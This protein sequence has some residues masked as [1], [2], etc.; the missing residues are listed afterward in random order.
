MIE[1]FTKVA[2]QLRKLNNYSGLRAVTTAVNNAKSEQDP[3]TVL[4]ADKPVWMKE[5]KTMEVL[6]STAKMH[7]SYRLALK[8]TPDAA[9]VS[10]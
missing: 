9:I 8:N 3:V 10:M 2:W 6:M 4:L 5:I 7:G 1:H